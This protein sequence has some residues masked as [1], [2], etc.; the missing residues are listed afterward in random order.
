MKNLFT[1]NNDNPIYY[2]FVIE[3]LEKNLLS[4]HRVVLEQVAIP[5]GQDLANRKPCLPEP[6]STFDTYTHPIEVRYQSDLRTAE[7]E[8]QVNIQP[9]YIDSENAL[10]DEELDQLNEK[11]EKLVN[12][13]R[14]KSAEVERTDKSQLKKDR[15]YK[16]FIR[17]LIFLISIA[18]IFLSGSAL[19]NIGLSK[20]LSYGIGFILG[21]GIFFLAEHMR[22]IVEKGRTILQKRI[23]VISI[24]TFLFI[25]FMFLGK[26]RVL[27]YTNS[28]LEGS[29]GIKPIFFALINM[30]ITL[31]AVTTIYFTRLNKEERASIDRYKIKK[32]EV[33]ILIKD[34]KK[35]IDRIKEV[36]ILKA[37]QELTRGQIIDY[38]KYIR[39][40]IQGYYEEAIREFQA[41]NHKYRIDGKTVEFFKNDVKQLPEIKV[42]IKNRV[43]KA[44]ALLLLPL[45]CFSC[46]SDAIDGKTV[47]VLRDITETTFLAQPDY[48]SIAPTLG[49]EE[50]IWRSSTFRYGTL[51]SL[52]HTKRM[53]YS[54]NGEWSL[55][56]NEIERRGKVKTFLNDV[57]NSLQVSTDS[58]E[59]K[60]SSIWLP[61]VE[62]IA[63][64]QNKP[65]GILFIFSDIAENSE[66]FYSISKSEQKLLENSP[67]EVKQRFL[68]AALKIRDGMGNVEVV[69]VYQPKNRIEDSYFSLMKGLYSDIFDELSIPVT[70]VTNL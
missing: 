13:H 59:H 67:D 41:T 51:S 55:L 53:E 34:L 35:I 2:R 48:K 49:L 50:N 9:E 40:L 22:D 26:M 5:L 46:S 3:K 20:G 29:Q 18:D 33:N 65:S 44:L 14:I 1:K 58:T 8:L 56:G 60:F 66:L 30:F 37:K 38:A 36:K 15:R 28:A 6:D 70:F 11:K 47:S 27:G 10:A 4:N 31:I 54:L 19:E 25:L 69:I 24:F 45:I 23:I 16:M 7:V 52:Q 21:C 32:D 61:I 57:K 39:N 12:D 63:L 43:A 62:E 68:N 64:L 42:E 17:P